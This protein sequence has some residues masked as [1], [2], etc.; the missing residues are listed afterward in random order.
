MVSR[1]LLYFG[2]AS[3][4]FLMACSTYEEGPE[5]SIF[6][7]SDRIS[8][9]WEWAAYIDNEVFRTGEWADSTIQFTDNNIVRICAGDA[10]RE[11][12]WNFVRKRTKLQLIFGRQTIA[13]DI[14]MLRRNEIWL[15]FS[16]PDTS[17]VIEWELVPIE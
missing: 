5:I 12:S 8:N 15:Y 11:G 14:R 16:D 4:L 17:R 7:A 6:P 2:L 13:Y 10:C 1:K 9:T 3:L